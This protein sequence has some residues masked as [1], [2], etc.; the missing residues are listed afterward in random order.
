M[1]IFQ[2][3]TVPTSAVTVFPAVRASNLNGRAFN[4]PG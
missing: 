2:P 1:P 3:R 4:L